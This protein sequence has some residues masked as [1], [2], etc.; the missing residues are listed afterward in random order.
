MKAGM[1]VNVREMN[2]S[3]ELTPRKIRPN[4]SISGALAA[5]HDVDNAAPMN[6]N[7]WLSSIDRFLYITVIRGAFKKFVDWHS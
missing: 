1:Q 2:C 5:T 6:T 3:P 4:M 7:M